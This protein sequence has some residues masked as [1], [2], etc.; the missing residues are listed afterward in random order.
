MSV[1]PPSNHSRTAALRRP[2]PGPG[3]G[4][5][6]VYTPDRAAYAPLLKKLARLFEENRRLS[7]E[8]LCGAGCARWLVFFDRGAEKLPRRGTDSDG[9]VV[10]GGFCEFDTPQKVATMAVDF[11]FAKDALVMFVGLFHCAGQRRF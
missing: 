9:M 11:G 1:R 5:W 4:K 2:E 6:S 3:P 7:R 8:G 10:T